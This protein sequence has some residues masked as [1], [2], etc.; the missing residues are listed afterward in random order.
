MKNKVCPKCG[1]KNLVHTGCEVYCTRC[2]W[3]ERRTRLDNF[4]KDGDQT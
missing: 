3:R 2:Q 4:I 1:N